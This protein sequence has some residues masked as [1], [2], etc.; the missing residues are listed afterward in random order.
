M[1]PYVSRRE[2]FAWMFVL[3]Q[4]GV[5]LGL[6]SIKVQQSSFNR[7]QNSKTQSHLVEDTA[8]KSESWAGKAPNLQGSCW[9]STDAY[10]MCTPSLAID[11]VLVS[12]PDHVWLVKRKD[13]G[14][15]ATLGGFVEV[16]ESAEDAA[17]RELKEEA[18][19][20]LKSKL[21]LLGFY[22]DPKRD[23]RR[24]TASVV[25]VVNVP[26]GEN[27]KAADDVKEVQRFHI[28]EV[29]SLNLFADHKTILRD[30]LCSSKK[31]PNN[32]VVKG[33]EL[34]RTNCRSI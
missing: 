4:F 5:I 28:G 3:V 34:S 7:P 14:Q 2:A 24:H 16:G 19:L 20:D 29:E 21:V 9:C 12:E 8:M 13:T 31:A 23:K 30:Y 6:L 15:Y 26:L 1:L 11:L 10:C 32:C 25:Y 33:D 22:S 27:P 17:K 18:G